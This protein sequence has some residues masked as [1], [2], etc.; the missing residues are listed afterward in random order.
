MKSMICPN[1]ACHYR[2]APHKKAK[3]SILVL[4][5]LLFLGVV[6]GL[7]YMLVMSGYRYC[8]PNCGIQVGTD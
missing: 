5:I 7:I 6:P 4:L 2:G 8:C 3:G 1:P